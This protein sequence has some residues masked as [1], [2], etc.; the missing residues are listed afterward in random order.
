MPGFVRIADAVCDGSSN[1][2]GVP[3]TRDEEEDGDPGAIRTHDLSLRRGPLY[4]AELRGHRRRFSH[5]ADRGTTRRIQ[6]R[7][8]MAVCNPLLRRRRT[9]M[10]IRLD[11][12]RHPAVIALLQEHL[13]WMHRISP[14]GSLHALDLEALRGPGITLSGRRGRATRSRAVVRCVSWNPTMVK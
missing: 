4:P 10:D 5:E 3:S 9:C 14:P 12:L 8:R 13:D 7:V 11:D 1:R 2:R 6:R